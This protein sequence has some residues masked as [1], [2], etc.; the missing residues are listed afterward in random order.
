MISKFLRR[1]KSAV[2]LV[3]RV[4]EE[5]TVVTM[6]QYARRFFLLAR[7]SRGSRPFLTPV[8]RSKPVCRRQ[9]ATAVEADRK[10]PYYVTS[11]IFYVN[12]GVFYKSYC[13]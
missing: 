13:H 9:L 2:D 3:K 4:L 7:S 10:K 11:P 12:A 6:E 5:A 1:G 8:H